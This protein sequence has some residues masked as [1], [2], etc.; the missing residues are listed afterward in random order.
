MV[1]VYDVNQ[2]VLVNQLALKLKSDSKLK[3]PDWAKFVKTGPNKERHPLSEDW[4]YFRAAS[5]LRK[6]YFHGPIGVAKLRTKYGSKKNRG[7]VP[8]KFVKA[9]GKIIRVILQ[10]LESAGYIKKESDSQHKGRK[11][12]P[13]GV[14]LVDKVAGDVSKLSAS[15]AKEDSDS[16]KQVKKESKKE[17]ASETKSEE[18]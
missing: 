16:N 2:D 6:I 5:I 13:K 11:I 18:I 17:I 15:K 9:S 3:I 1:K 4:W 7:V 14:S 10:Q 12:S 8:S